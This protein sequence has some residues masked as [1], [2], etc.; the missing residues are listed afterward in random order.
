MWKMIDEFKVP[1]RVNED[2]TIQ[3]FINGK[4]RDKK[5]FMDKSSLVVSIARKDGKTSKK[6][7][8]RLVASAFYGKICDDE[9]VIHKNGV[10]SDNRL[11]NLDVVKKK[12]SCMRA[13][14]MTTRRRPCVAIDMHGKEVGMYDSMSAA[15]RCEHLS[16]STIYESCHDNSGA[17]VEKT[18]HRYRFI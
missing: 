18:G 17:L 14:N 11:E 9:V 10:I 15:A 13:K 5:T 4:W 16:D 6:T 3:K 2:G 1:Y 7:V 8:G 12:G